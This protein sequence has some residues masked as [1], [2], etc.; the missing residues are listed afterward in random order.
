MQQFFKAIH[1]FFA[2]T[3]FLAKH[4]LLHYYLMPLALSIVLQ[5]SL[6][7]S[8]VVF[9]KYLAAQV[10]GTYMPQTVTEFKGFWQF[11]NVFAGFSLAKVA[12]FIIGIMVFLISSKFSKYLVLILLSPVFALLSE[13]VEEKITGIVLPFNTA[14]FLKDIVRGIVLAMRNLLIELALIAVFTIAGLFG[15]PF[16][17]LVVPILW[18]ISAYFYG[19]SMMDYTC[20]RRKM[21]I[22]QSVDFVRQNRGLALGNGAMYLILEKIPFVGLCIAPINAVV[23]AT[24]CILEEGK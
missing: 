14:Q 18:L 13:K 16:A 22:S 4:K 12:A 11:L 20:E 7:A 15:G 6:F 9:S 5:I 8:I 1:H 24:T 2:A 3:R 17:L 21:S 10:L 23:S 19:F